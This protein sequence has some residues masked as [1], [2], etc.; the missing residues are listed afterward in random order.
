[1]LTLKKKVAVQIQCYLWIALLMFT[2]VGCSAKKAFFEVSGLQVER[3]LNANKALGVNQISCDVETSSVTV[4]SKQLKQKV[5]GISLSSLTYT[6]G[7]DLALFH[8]SK[9]VQLDYILNIAGTD[10]PKYILYQQFKLA[11]A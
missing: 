6:T 3:S 1:M 10:P 9:G 11:I 5:K 4:S 8:H 7:V 2:T